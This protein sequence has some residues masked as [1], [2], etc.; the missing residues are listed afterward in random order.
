LV[1]HATALRQKMRPQ[2]ARAGRA[3]GTFSARRGVVAVA[4]GAS[5]NASIGAGVDT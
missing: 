1:P 2:D 3:P 4:A 5:S